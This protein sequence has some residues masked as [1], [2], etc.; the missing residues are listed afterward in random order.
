MK[1][2]FQANPDWIGPV[3]KMQGIGNNNDR[4]DVYPRGPSTQCHES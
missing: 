2:E 3:R 1:L 4:S